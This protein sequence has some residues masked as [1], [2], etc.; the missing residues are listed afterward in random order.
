MIG[1]AIGNWVIGQKIGE[2]GMGQVYLGQHK[3]LH[4]KAAIKVLF[5]ALANDSRFRERF[6]QE[7][8]S[9]SSLQHPNIAQVLDYVEQEGQY[10]LVMEYLAGGTLSEAIERGAIPIPQALSWARQALKALDYAHQHRII[11]RDVKPS[12]IMLDRNGQ[13][14]VLDFGIAMVMGGRRLTSSGVAIGTAEYMSPEQITRPQAVDH[15]TDVYSMGIVLYEM[16]TGKLP[17]EGESEYNVKNAQ[18]HQPPPSMRSINPAIPEPLEY[19]VLRAI[20]KDPNQRYSGCGEFARAI[21]DFE[22]NRNIA[23]APVP[24][25]QPPPR[26]LPAQPKRRN[27]L[28]IGL[29]TAA[30]LLVLFV[31]GLGGLFY[32][33]VQPS[34]TDRYYQLREA[35]E[36]NRPW[37]EVEKEYYEKIRKTPQDTM[38][39]GLLIEALLRQ[40]NSADAEKAARE[41]IKLE[42]DE[43]LWRDLLGDAL[44][45]QGKARKSEAAEAYQQAFNKEDSLADRHVY[46]GDIMQLNG[47]WKL[48]INEYREAVRLKPERGLLKAILASILRIQAQKV[49]NEGEEKEAEALFTEA[50]SFTRGAVQ[51]APNKAAYHDDLGYLFYSQKKWIE[52]EAAYREAIKFNSFDPQYHSHLGEALD[53]QN[54]YLLAEAAHRQAVKLQPGEA[55]YYNVLG[56]NLGKQEKWKEAEAV[57]RKAIDLKAEEAESYFNL[58]YVLFKQN[59][60]DEAKKELQQAVE[61]NGNYVGAREYLGLVLARQEKWKEAEEQY[62]QATKLAPNEAGYYYGVGYTRLQQREYSTAEAAFKEAIRLNPKDSEYY[63]KLG[64]AVYFQDKFLEAE[65]AYR[66]AVRLKPGE[67]SYQ[68]NLKIIQEKLSQ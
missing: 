61:L 32:L 35:L 41:A 5:H 27:W 37:A 8:S 43:A 16:L 50:E 45:Y 49:Q 39:Y 28:K 9:Q 1:T 59:R 21:E 56:V 52:A 60:L 6:L 22:Q 3:T 34:K 31:A 65:A 13:A 14:R 47:E 40:R 46:Q 63:A 15:R 48:A 62:H 33:A 7:A 55:N 64:N 2:G 42:P 53:Q 17:F 44:G 38:L 57:H 51:L 30:C 58:G 11:H 23:V 10:Y 66:E 24:V 25:V 54:K 29:L 26:S 67:K 4:T 18:V 36:T 19:I 68:D 12:N 20:A